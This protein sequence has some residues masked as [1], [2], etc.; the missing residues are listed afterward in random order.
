MHGTNTGRHRAEPRAY[1]ALALAG[2]ARAHP[3]RGPCP[4]QMRILLVEDEVTIATTLGDDLTDA[5]HEVV[6]IGDGREAIRHLRDDAFDG[7][8]TDLRLPG[9]HGAEVVSAARR[10]GAQLPILVISGSFS[11]H[12]PLALLELGAD[13]CVAKPFCNEELIARLEALVSRRS[14]PPDAR[15]TARAG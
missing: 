9:V 6:T 12:D 4:T 3:L 1:G 13:E 11:R 7:V 10:A 14:P 8:I 15:P 5:G 2:A